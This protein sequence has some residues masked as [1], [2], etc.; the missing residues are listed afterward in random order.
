MMNHPH[1]SIRFEDH[2]EALKKARRQCSCDLRIQVTFVRA[3]MYQ[4]E[5]IAGICR[6]IGV[7]I[8]YLSTPIRKEGMDLSK[9]DMNELAAI[10]SD[11]KV[12]TIF[13]ERSA[14]P[15]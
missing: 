10:F 14:D 1:G 3:N 13:D 8:V 12:K 15:C 7:D 6:D 4:T 9:R 5:Q 11:F 2:V